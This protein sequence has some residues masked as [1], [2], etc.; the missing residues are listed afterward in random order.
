MK[1]ALPISL[2]LVVSYFPREQLLHCHRKGNQQNRIP[3]TQ[4][5]KYVCVHMLPFNPPSM[6][7]RQIWLLSFPAEAG[8][9]PHN[10]SMNRLREIITPTY[11]VGPRLR[12]C[13]SRTWLAGGHRGGRWLGCWAGCL[14][15]QDFS[16]EAA[17]HTKLS[18]PK[19]RALGFSCELRDAHTLQ[20]YIQRTMFLICGWWINQRVYLLILTSQGPGYPLS[21]I[22]C[23]EYWIWK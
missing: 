7:V 13:G 12:E 18:V 15:R 23:V 14:G 21:Y 20:Y 5:L 4:A 1:W 9:C 16:F 22:N 11:S 6:A 10:I 19:A 8:E 3:T 2:F 17:I